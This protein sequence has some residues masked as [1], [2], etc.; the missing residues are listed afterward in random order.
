MYNIKKYIFLNASFP[1][2]KKKK[3]NTFYHCNAMVRYKRNFYMKTKFFFSFCFPFNSIQKYFNFCHIVLFPSIQF[4]YLFSLI[5][6]CFSFIP[7]IIQHT[8]YIL[9]PPP[10]KKTK[11]TVSFIIHW[12]Q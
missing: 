12:K 3:S 7:F 10:K 2:F 9:P 6:T 4:F 1:C 8:L 5:F 11:K